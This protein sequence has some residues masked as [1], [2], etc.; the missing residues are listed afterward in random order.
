MPTSGGAADKL[1]NQYE[2]LWAIDQLMRIVDGEADRLTPEPHDPDESRGIEFIVDVGATH[3]YWSVKRQ[4]AEAAGWTL[5]RL[6]RKE[7]GRSILSDLL[8]HTERDPTNRAVFASTQAASHFEE[9]RS[10][11]ENR[12]SLESRLDQ[13]AKL[14]SGFRDRILPLCGGDME[15]ARVFLL[16]TRSHAAD[17]AQLRRRVDFA[18][19]KLLY[20][21]D[22][23]PLDLAAVRGHLAKL[24]LDS[25]HRPLDRD[26]ILRTLATHGI[27]LR[28]WALDKSVRSRI[29]EMCLEYVAPLRSQL[30]NGT[31][32][33]LAGSEA[34][35]GADGKPAHP[36]VLVVG[37][38]GAGK[39]S[40]LADVVERLRDSGVPV[41][42]V[43]FDQLPEGILSTTE[44]G[45]KLL[46]PESPALVL[47]G[48]ADGAPSVLLIDQLD[49]VSLA[50]GRRASLWSLFEGLR[51]EAER[52]PGISLIVGCREF[53]L[54]HDHRM[55]TLKADASGFAVTELKP[56]SNDQ[57]D[58]ALQV[59]GVEPA[60]VQ[61]TLKSILVVPLHL[62]MFLGLAPADRVGVRNRDELFDSFWTECE[63][64]TDMRLGRKAAWTPVIDRL[65]TWLS[66]NQQLSAPCHVLDEFSTDAGAMTSE[67]VLVLAG[68]RYRFF[69]ESFFDYA[70]ARRFAAGGGR[71]VDDLLLVGE[72]HLFRRAQVRQVLSYHRAK[73]RPR[74]LEELES[75]LTDAGVRFHLKA[76][77]LQ[78]LSS[79][80]EPRQDEWDVLQKPHD[81]TPDFSAHVSRVVAG[82]AGWFDVLD[83]AGFFDAALSS[84]DETREQEAVWMLG[85][86]ETLEKRS[87]RVAALLSTH[88]KPDERWNRYLRHVCRMGDVF[89][90]REMFDFFLS[91]I[92]D[93]TLDGV[94]PGFAVNDDWWSVLYTIGQK[95]PDL[96]C[97]AIGRW[98]DR[99][100]ATWG[101]R[102]RAAGDLA[103]RGSSHERGLPKHLDQSGNGTSVIFAAAKAPLS[104]VEHL[105]P[106]VAAFVSETATERRDRL[107]ED[108]LWSFRWFGDKC[109]A[110]HDA[111][112]EG[113]AGSLGA[114]AKT[115]PTEL[116]R[117]LEPYLDRP[118]DTIAYLVLRAWTAAPE[119]Y[120]DR[121]ADYLAAEP[122]RLKVGYSASGGG[123][124]VAHYVSAKAVAAAS[125]LCSSGR[126]TALEQAI[127]Q[128][129]DHWE[130]THP[131]TRG[132][133]QLELLE[134]L[135]G[136]RLGEVGCAKLNELR[137]KFPKVEFSPPRAM[138]VVCVGSPIP[139]EA[140]AKMSDKHWLLAMQKY[141]GL[142]HR[143]G[144]EHELSGGERQLAQSVQGRAQADPVRFAALAE[145]MPDD[146]PASYFDAIVRGVADCI[147]P[148]RDEAPPP[149]ALE[150]VI[151]LVR[152]VHSLPGRPCGRAIST[153]IEKWTDRDWPDEVID[154]VAWYAV[155]DRDPE[156]ELWQTP[157]HEGE[158]YYGGDPYSAG[159]NSTRGAIAGAVA[160]L[161]FEAPQRFE[162][163]HDAVHSLANDRSTAVRSC[164]IGALVA[165]LNTDV[166]K[167]VSWFD[168]CVTA[169]P[170]ILATPHVERFVSFA[171]Y[172]DF[173][174]VR[175]AI[176]M[177]LAATD[178][179]AVKAGALQVCLLALNDEVAGAAEVARRVECGSTAMRR[180]A[181]GVYAGNVANEV[182]GSECRQL[183]KPFFADPE[184]SVR[185]EA[186]SAFRHLA[187]LATPDQ[188]DL[189][190]AFLDSAPGPTAL[191]PVVRALEDS[192]VQLPDLVCRLAEV[193]VDAFRAEAADISTSGSMVAMD[194]SK[195]VVRLY[196]QTA[197]PAVQ[198]RCLD[199]IDE[200]ERHH[201]MGLSDELRR[202]DR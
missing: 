43:R 47:A 158:F 69:H 114:L 25:I 161:L 70:F 36:E 63:R 121:M 166:P 87:A 172:R 177:M 67:R 171:G 30:I 119:V 10:H 179:R 192:P 82:H 126:F 40:T 16:R 7:R 150:Q 5:A 152:R 60:A 187:S 134:S 143:R 165:V 104:F 184:E 131:Q 8:R 23:S 135:D 42:P 50:S 193:C 186:A 77:V 136:A 32:L 149:I 113:L 11:A 145:R 53:D 55:R 45:R 64:R 175:P 103:D 22:G 133:A 163:L 56:L 39:S 34:I 96:A 147:P 159:I 127:V 142:D 200:M 21:A 14:D 168:D 35:L 93:G 202:L 124:S 144:R 156:E 182:V 90:S 199:L 73:D 81:S 74:Y 107:Q 94:R 102:Q 111:L 201:F 20:S 188:A 6:A 167:A 140:Q 100:I 155:N 28:E 61:P 4:T 37:G 48:V 120:G 146:L 38:A 3:E 15:R 115:A 66:A 97:E 148:E 139:E 84:G 174:G 117:L 85:L 1:G 24:L 18:V 91:L 86:H 106:R 196:A 180:A 116:D 164:A 26:A 162:R 17:E 83:S 44:L 79:L 89:H 19:R 59:A 160:R 176:D 189:L 130:E 178:P 109:H 62:S 71:L 153:L 118:H 29:D 190:A 157:A 183:L 137:N 95:R 123:G 112:L 125:A 122:R 194:L 198:S 2:T 185:D 170:A 72:Q 88:R 76:L 49:A 9:L 92:G 101:G 12:K 129:R 108:P 41:L 33:P 99:A 173:A 54:E 31:F 181:A 98:F 80:P 138:E 105:L 65:I 132:I 51:R 27:G 13:S 141:A 191:A 78:W 195:I 46:L 128:L 110:T 197:D 52:L 58:T 75:V 151:A 68:D 57:I 169:H 154:A